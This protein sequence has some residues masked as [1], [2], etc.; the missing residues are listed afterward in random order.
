MSRWERAKD[1]HGTDF[2][3][4]RSDGAVALDRPANAA[5]KSWIIIGPQGERHFKMMG[6]PARRAVIKFL[7][8]EAAMR[9]A[10]KLWPV[11]S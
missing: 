4:L 1:D 11:K 5:G 2:K 9:K 10:D 6:T 8:S 7:T 3:W